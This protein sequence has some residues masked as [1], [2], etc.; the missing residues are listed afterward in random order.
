MPLT[1]TMMFHLHIVVLSFFVV[2]AWRNTPTRV[3]RYV[4]R[5]SNINDS[6]LQLQSLRQPSEIDSMVVTNNHT[7]L[8]CHPSLHVQRRQ[9][10]LQCPMFAMVAVGTVVTGTCVPCAAAG[11]VG[12]RITAAVTTSDLGVS[13]RRSIVRGAQIMDQMDLQ[14]ERWSD[15]F[16]LGSE[17][18]QRSSRPMP[19]SIPPLQ[20]LD[21]IVASK[22]VDST[23][24]IF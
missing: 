2:H 6:V 1:T 10:F 8:S 20:E 22:I 15:Q 11:E 13:V 16:R 7:I 23:D 4:Q 5:Q 17:R 24:H 14:S 12:A 9:F 21:T 3:Y 18:A 19:K